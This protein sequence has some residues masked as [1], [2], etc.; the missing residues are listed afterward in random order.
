M[1]DKIK[2]DAGFK[3]LCKSFVFRFKN[4]Q[5]EQETLRVY[6]HSLS[7]YMTDE[8]WRKSINKLIL[9]WIPEFGRSFPTVK[10]FLDAVGLSP[11]EIAKK[12][13]AVLKIKILKYGGYEA[14]TL[15]SEHR[16]YVAMEAV[17]RMGGWFNVAQSGIESWERN[18]ERFCREYVD[19]YFS[20]AIPKTPLLGG[21]D[22]VN[23]RFLEQEKI[24]IEKMDKNKKEPLQIK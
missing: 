23:Q 11:E 1:I 19:L 10:D 3:A 21:S 9:T 14:I 18:K 22:L 20:D 13:H 7:K 4:S 15:G 2:F 5:E 12:A 16:H 8:D 24:K 6:H 17:R